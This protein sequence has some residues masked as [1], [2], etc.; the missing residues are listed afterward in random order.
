MQDY[1]SVHVAV[2]IGPILTHTDNFNAKTDVAG[3]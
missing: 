2:T 1:M 3:Q